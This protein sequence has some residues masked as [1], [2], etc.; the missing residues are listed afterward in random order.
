MRSVVILFTFLAHFSIYAQV[1]LTADGPGNTYEL[2]TSKLAPGYNPIEAPGMMREDCDNHLN[3]GKHI[4]EVFDNELAKNVFKFVIH[5][6][7]DNDRCKTFDRQRN[8]I[9]S[10][11]SSPDNLKATIGETVEYKWKFKLDKNFKPSKNFTHLHQLKSVG[12]T[13]KAKPII[14][15]TARKGSVDKLELRHSSGKNQN[16]LKKVDLD[17]L[18]GHWVMV[19]EKVTYGNAGKTSYNISITNVKTEN[20]I[21]EYHNNTLQIWN[22]GAEFV[23]PK[24]GIYRSLKNTQS[25]RDEE[26]LFAD[27]SIRESK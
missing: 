10:Y 15:L 4:S 14:T 9:K 26:V 20:I 12:E 13:E 16:T 17:L 22:A 19:T 5:V 27:F 11:K 6:K 2:I 1:T 23:R 3:Y 24:W 25:L 8:E 21:L 18:R 7:E